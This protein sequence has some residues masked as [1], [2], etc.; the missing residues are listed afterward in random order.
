MPDKSIVLMLV[1][2]Q[3]FMPQQESVC[4]GSRVLYERLY[5]LLTRTYL[6]LLDTCRRLEH[7]G[8]PFAFSL[9]LSPSLCALLEDSG[10]CDGYL[11]Y[12]DKLVLLGESE[13]ERRTGELMQLAQMYLERLRYIRD[14]FAHTLNRHILQEFKRLS[15]AGHIELLG[16]TATPVFLPQYVDLTEAVNAQIEVGMISHRHY[17]GSVPSGFWLPQMGYAEGLEKNLKSFGLKYS[18]LDAQGLLC[19]EPLPKAGIFYP[20]QCA[21]AFTFFAGDRT[22]PSVLTAKTAYHAA[23]TYRAESKDVSF[24]EQT[25]NLAGFIPAGGMRVASGF[26][27]NAQKDSGTAVYDAAAAAAQVQLDAED[28][29]RR[30]SDK[31]SQAAVYEPDKPLSVIC[32]CRL[33]FLG[34]S[35]YEGV[36]WL[37]QVYRCAAEHGVSCS[38]CA[39]VY[40]QSPAEQMVRP[41]MS[42]APDTGYGENLIH[43]ANS[44]IVRYVRKASERMIDLAGRFS[45]SSGLKARILNLAAKEVLLAQSSTWQ[46]M[47]YDQD[48]QET[49]A[50]HTKEL[51]NSF[52]TIYDSLGANSISTEWLI[53]CEK[54]NAIFPWINY[55]VF[56]RKR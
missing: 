20:V 23:G 10:V 2:H 6:P 56:S 18:V 4:E 44:W 52:T 42:A 5:E 27:Y 26:S 16:T 48:C 11:Q 31:L 29:V 8:V 17:F 43:A 40:R 45:D 35:W 28:F 49:A 24:H 3:E 51:L 54:Q 1:G 53:R 55:R 50:R 46:Q 33:D 12:L 38:T 22:T 37:E 13:T 25:E 47:L 36:A 21:N 30:Q 14:F 39:A 9:V 32:T 19:G 7:D 34:G 15:D 41:C